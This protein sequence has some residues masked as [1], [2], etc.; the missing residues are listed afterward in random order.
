M[1][2]AL[3]TSEETLSLKIADAKK[4]QEELKEKIEQHLL[5]AA[6]IN[7]VD[8]RKAEDSIQRNSLLI[9][10]SVEREQADL[11]DIQREKERR[12]EAAEERKRRDMRIIEEQYESSLKKTDMF[13]KAETE[14]ITKNAAKARENW[15]QFLKQAEEKLAALEKLKPQTLL[16]LE[17]QLR[18][19]EKELEDC[20][21]V[22]KMN[23]EQAAALAASYKGPQ[24]TLEQERAEAIARHKAEAAKAR[25]E[26]E[27]ELVRKIKEDQDKYNAAHPKDDSD[28][29][30]EDD[31]ESVDEMDDEEFQKE[32]QRLKEEQKKKLLYRPPPVQEAP[33]IPSIVG[34]TKQKKPLK[35]VGFRN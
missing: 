27:Q 3:K 14:R 18:K 13:V 31:K 7:K 8:K 10:T 30:T 1:Q 26:A 11:E 24:K 19:V 34:D 22:R 23:E 9:K 33:P 32:I 29:E 17:A 15:A 12:Y 5:T 16:S 20:A 28:S 25:E 2:S 4:R 21:E 35:K 6:P